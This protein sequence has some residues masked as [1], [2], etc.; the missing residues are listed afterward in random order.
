MRPRHAIL[1]TP[2]N[3]CAFAR[4]LGEES[5][6]PTQLISRPH[7]VRVS[8]LDATLMI[9]PASVANKRLTIG[10]SSLDAT[11]MR[12]TGGGG[13]LLLTRL[14]T[15]H[16]YPERPSGAEGP[17]SH[18]AKCVCPTRP[19]VPAF[20]PRIAQNPVAHPSFFSITCNMPLAQLFSFDNLPFSWGGMGY[21]QHSNLQMHILHPG[22]VFGTCQHSNLSDYP[23]VPNRTDDSILPHVYS[24]CAILPSPRLGDCPFLPPWRPV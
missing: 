19:N 24:R 4:F 10:L 11:L 1:L 3:L 6:H 20:N 13:V 7:T 23:P 17:L 5:P 14:A 8:P 2:S 21:S 9:F 12:N 16:V 15:K 22:C 18:A